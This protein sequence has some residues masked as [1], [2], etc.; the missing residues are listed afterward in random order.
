MCRKSVSGY[1]KKLIEG[2]WATVKDG[3][4]KLSSYNSL[5]ERY[6]LKMFGKKLL[7]KFYKITT[8]KQIKLELR[9]QVIYDLQLIQK[10]AVEK[11]EKVALKNIATSE[12]RRRSKVRRLCNEQSFS[13]V[14]DS[15]KTSQKKIASQ[16]GLK[17]H[18][19]GKYWSDKLEA[20]K[21]ISV[22]RNKSIPVMKGNNK[23]LSVL[24]E[25]TNSSLFISRTGIIFK[26]ICNDICTYGK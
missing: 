13:K 21:L 26:R 2:G 20:E 1:V 3:V 25:T 15:C 12:A 7:G 16:M 10:I 14:L 24:R 5:A 8:V 22:R 11:K 17:F 19:S 4:L 23:M 6:G 9:R 18:S